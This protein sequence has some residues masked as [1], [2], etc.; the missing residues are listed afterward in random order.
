MA[1]VIIY[2]NAGT[3]KTRRADQLLK[4]YRCSKLIEEWDGVSPLPDGAL[5]LTNHP[6]PDKSKADFAVSIEQAKLAI[7]VPKNTR[8]K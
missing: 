5:A 7:A 1:K 8:F 2:G 4:H 6:N 3:G